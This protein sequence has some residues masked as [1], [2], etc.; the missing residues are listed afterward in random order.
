[1]LIAICVLRVNGS[2]FE[3]S[4]SDVEDERLLRFNRQIVLFNVDSF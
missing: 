3:A 2:G 1:M 4:A